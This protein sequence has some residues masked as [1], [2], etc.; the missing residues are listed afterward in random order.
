MK[1]GLFLTPGAARAA[2]QVGA[3]QELLRLG[4]R[5]D[6]VGA[7]SVGSLNAAF[8][9][10]G[11]VD[12]LAELWAGWRTA[13]IAGLDWAE[14][15]RGA[16]FRSRNL[17]HNR[18][19]KE[20][21]ID[22]HLND[23]PLL[24]G[25]RL[26]FNL[27]NLTTGGQEILE[28]PGGPM[29][30]ADGVNASVAVPGA[31]RPVEA[32][33]AQLA[34]GLTVDGF[35][36]ERVLLEVGLDRAFVVGVA[37]RA[38][39]D[40]PVRNPYQSLLRAVEW[41]QYSETLLGLEGAEQVNELVRCWYADRAAVEAAVTALPLEPAER[42]ALLA[43]VE[44][45]YAEAGFPYDRQP[46]EIVPILPDREIPMFFTSYRPERSRRL[47]ELGRRDAAAV[48]EGLRS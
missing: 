30:L 25:V 16:L 20:R 28:W 33:G 17:M 23:A 34:D 35:P 10:T 44:R 21:V 24:P 4:V 11:Q 31:I 22:A 38:P 19:Q 48:L 1:T 36:L 14:L 39:I 3:V 43:E 7:S 9:A 6:V 46:V 15:L 26:R 42:A 37:P 8:V 47:L 18:P 40:R 2:Y 45:A 5:F 29:A 41:N 27:A 32:L 12:R 13:D